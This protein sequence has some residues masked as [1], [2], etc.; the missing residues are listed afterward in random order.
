M[1]WRDGFGLSFSYY[2]LPEV[3]IFP[4]DGQKHCLSWVTDSGMS[5]AYGIHFRL[6][7][8]YLHDVS[9]LLTI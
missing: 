2:D 8:G 7:H 9:S 6:R 4:G 5:D 1:F 3:D